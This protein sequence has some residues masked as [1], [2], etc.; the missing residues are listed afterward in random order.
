[1]RIRVYRIY[2]YSIIMILVI[3]GKFQGKLDFVKN[4]FDIDEKHIFDCEKKY[5]FNITYKNLNSTDK[6][7]VV[8]NLEHYVLRK[9]EEG[10]DTKDILV[11]FMSINFDEKTIFICDDVSEGLVP[12]DKVERQYRENLGKILCYISAHSTDVY[13]VLYGI[14]RKIK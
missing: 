4:N 7:S 9:T 13:N 6:F 2:L 12:L 10:L 14:G 5:L 1:M 3:G 8:D 11:D